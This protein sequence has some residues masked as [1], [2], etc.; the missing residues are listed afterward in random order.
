MR[1]EL[2]A[3]KV[4]FIYPDEFKTPCRE[5][6][7]SGQ[8]VDVIGPDNP[9]TADEDREAFGE[10]LMRCRT[11]EG[12]EFVAFETELEVHACCSDPHHGF[13][14]HPR[15]DNCDNWQG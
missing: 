1:A 13:G 6:E 7:L 5:M 9:E 3:L 4:K 10:C 8:I 12:E 2:K 15:F 11:L 14:A